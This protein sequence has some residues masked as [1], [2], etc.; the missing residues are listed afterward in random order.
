ML[1]A[2]FFFPSSPRDMK[3]EKKFF[4]SSY[5]RKKKLAKTAAPDSAF[6]CLSAPSTDLGSN[7]KH[8]FSLFFSFWKEKSIF[9]GQNK[10]ERF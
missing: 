2:K 5:L 8:C 1:W 7:V 10:K 4:P 6:L 3:K 9:A